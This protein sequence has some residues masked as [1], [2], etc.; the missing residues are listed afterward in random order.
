M[1]RFRSHWIALAALA[2]TSLAFGAEVHSVDYQRIDVSPENE[3]RD[4]ALNDRGRAP[5]SLFLGQV[6]GVDFDNPSEVFEYVFE[7][8][9]DRVTI[10]PTEDHFYFRFF[11]GD[12]FVWGNIHLSHAKRDKGAISFPYYAYVDGMKGPEETRIHA[13]TLNASNGLAVKKVHDFRYTLSYGDRE[14]VF[15][16]N[17]LSQASPEKEN[18]SAGEEVLFNLH[19]ES[20]LQ[21]YLIFNNRTND[22]MY[23]LNE[24]HRTDLNLKQLENN[25]WIDPVS[26]FAFFVD[27]QHQ[28]KIL[29]GVKR[30]N[31]QSNNYYDGP[32]DQLADNF[33][34]DWKLSTYIQT[35]YPYTR[36]K[37]DRHGSFGGRTRV[38]ISPYYAYA[39]VDS[40][41]SMVSSCTASAE[42]KS[43]ELYPCIAPDFQKMKSQMVA[44]QARQKDAIQFTVA[45]GDT[46][47][48]QDVTW[49]Y[50][51]A[52]F[53]PPGGSHMQDITWHYEEATF[54]PPGGSHMQ[55][56]TWHY[57]G[58]TFLPPGGSHMQDITWHYEEATFLPPGG[59]HMQD[60]T[61]HQKGATFLPP[62]GSHM[63]DI[64]WHLDGPTFLP[65]GGMHMQDITW[66]HSDATFLPPGGSHMQ[67]VTWHYGE[68]TFLPPGGMHM[69]DVTWHYKN[70]T[71][72]PPGGM[73]MQDVTWHYKDATFLPPGGSHMQDVTWHYGGATFLPPGGSHM[74]DITW[75]Y[76][77]ATFLPPGGSHMQD[78]TWHYKNATFL[79]P[80]GSHMQDVTW[81]YTNAT[82]LPPGGSHMQDITWHLTNATFLP[83]GSDVH[84]KDVSWHIVDTSE[85]TQDGDVTVAPK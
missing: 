77:N 53:L 76:A 78:V 11:I 80:G 66:H 17:Q 37:I 42:A 16:L 2:L 64:T 24:N 40:L 58:A 69:Q 74:Q 56:I 70:A 57:S 48:M 60:V 65:P 47:H 73:H 6:E 63:Q 41:L 21:F 22:F 38:A 45:T 82:F 55:D 29:I 19:D 31:V 10:T 61:W 12:Q 1:D 32:A 75:H 83:P 15:D 23:V 33:I 14:V 27:E 51:G 79:P 72:L 4:K 7:Q 43:E 39:D 44:K 54:L 28:R 85:I 71:F 46:G 49:H 50:E 8:L 81:H 13:Q 35:T 26:E 84:M 68:A 3:A 36:G 25:V 18:L 62:G 20:D 52:T 67:D 5:N 59:M 30:D 9:P 34:K